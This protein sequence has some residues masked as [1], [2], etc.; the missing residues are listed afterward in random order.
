MFRFDDVTFRY[1]PS[2]VGVVRQMFDADLYAELSGTFPPASLFKPD[3]GA[4]R[5]SS[6]SRT[7]DAKTFREFLASAP[8]WRELFRWSRTRD[9][10]D[11]TLTMLAAHS[12]DLGTAGSR[13][14]L[15][16]RLWRLAAAV[17]HRNLRNASSALR[18]EMTFVIM[19]ADGG[20]LLPHTD[21]PSKAVNLATSMMRPG[22]WD[23][24]FG[25]STD[26]DWPNDPRRIYSRGVDRLAFDDVHLLDSIAYAP[27]QAVIVVKTF[28]SWHSIRPMQGRGSQALRKTLNV[29]ILH[30]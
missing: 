13:A 4:S 1:E 17:K 23:P 7:T 30:N 10:L 16:Q 29:N 24:A 26:I 22:E 28:N 21:D 14:S 15:P 11:R 20:F 5:R 9:C 12:I 25:G 18:L 3:P 2:P 8:A 27:N 19:P 6:F